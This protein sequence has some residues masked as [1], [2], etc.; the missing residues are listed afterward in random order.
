VV[1]DLR[2]LILVGVYLACVNVYLFYKVRIKKEYNFLLVL[3][4][5]WVLFI[6]LIVLIQ[7]TVANITYSA[8]DVYQL[9]RFLKI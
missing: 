1:S 8:G 6:W 4:V 9:V 5:N 7:V 2:L 3:A